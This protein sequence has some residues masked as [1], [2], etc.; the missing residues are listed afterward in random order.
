[1]FHTINY[2]LKNSSITDVASFNKKFP[3]RVFYPL[4]NVFFQEKI[5]NK[6]SFL[7]LYIN[8]LH[9]FIIS[10]FIENLQEKR[11]LENNKVSLRIKYIM[12]IF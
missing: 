1:M 11:K 3:K 9:S 7:N 10:D 6:I 12:Y 4:K 5:S 2:N 8:I